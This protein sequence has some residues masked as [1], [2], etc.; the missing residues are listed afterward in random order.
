MIDQVGILIKIAFFL[1]LSN[2][3]SHILLLWHKNQHSSG[4]TVAQLCT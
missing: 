2:G 1:F 3:K 4:Q